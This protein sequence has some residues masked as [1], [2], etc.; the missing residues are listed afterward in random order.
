MSDYN[1]LPGITKSLFSREMIAKLGILTLLCIILAALFPTGTALELDY[2][3]GGIWARKDLI[4]PFSFPVYRDQLEYERDVAR[5]RQEIYPVFVRSSTE[6]AD[7]GA[8]FRALFNLIASVHSRTVRGTGDSLEIES[9][10]ASSE[11][12]FS[13]D[14]WELL[15]TLGNQDR[16]GALKERVLWIG[17]KCWD[18]GI[19]DRPK[20]SIKRREIAVRSG[21]AE[22]IIRTEALYDAD[23]LMNVLD[24]DLGELYGRQPSMLSLANR[25]GVILIRPNLLYD[26]EATTQS[27]AHAIEA[28]PRTTGFVQESE[29]IVSKHERITEEIRLKLE[30]LQ[31]ARAD[32]RGDENITAQYTGMFIHVLVVVIL[33]G[34]YL[35]LFRK[36]IFRSNRKLLLISI[37]LLLQGVF[38]YVSREIETDLPVEFLIAVPVTSMLL[39]I[40]FDSRVAFYGTVIVAF[41]VAGI[42]GNDYSLALAS[43][44]AGALSVYTVRD[45][46]NR[47]QIFRSMGFILIGY[48]ATIGAL[49]LERFTDPGRIAVQLSFGLIN[50]V[51]SPVLTY[52]LLF[53]FERLFKVTTDLTLIELGDAKHPLLVLLSEKAPGTYHHSMMIAG[54]A[55]KAALAIGANDVLARTGAYFHDIGK[56]VKPTYFVENQRGSRSRHAR[57]SPKRS[58]EVIRNHVANGVKLARE[59]G[60]PEEIIDCIPM[61]HGTTLTEFFYRKAL[62][63]AEEAGDGETAADV[64]IEDFRYPG[65]KPQTKETGILM[66][67]D[68]I[69][70]RVRSLDDQSAQNLKETIDAAVRKRFEEGEL[71]ECPLTIKDLT[72]IREAFHRVLVGAYHARIKYP[73]AQKVRKPRRTRKKKSTDTS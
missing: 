59:Y 38:A 64:N 68:A 42:R 2:K 52:G 30:S 23:E 3:V 36:A 25:I 33:F 16:L 19:L 62:S 10:K 73:D 39:A 50:A 49:A 67:A 61:H 11:I 21:T 51:I 29:R 47:T 58:A 48:A 34:I 4:A 54:M 57:L 8:R 32:R 70:A 17:T 28:I 26:Q 43:L 27:E 41:L 40:L 66:L 1:Q 69:E 60:L 6:V 5:V 14:D 55:E 63:D 71:D 53:S 9:L 18:V 56:L 15:M 44:V 20:N 12:P 7:R 35:A 72:L 37:L 24:T 45:I 22:S 13:P 46:R 65:P 31:R